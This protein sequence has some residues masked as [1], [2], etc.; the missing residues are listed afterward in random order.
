MVVGPHTKSFALALGVQV[1]YLRTYI[2]RLAVV[3]S[4]TCQWCASCWLGL[5]FAGHVLQCVCLLQHVCVCAHAVSLC[6]VTTSFRTWTSLTASIAQV[7]FSKICFMYSMWQSSAIVPFLFH[8]VELHDNFT[9][10][11]MDR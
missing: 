8:F 3:A 2:R 7:C 11:T 10:L 6:R 4:S 1:M 5:H 9:V